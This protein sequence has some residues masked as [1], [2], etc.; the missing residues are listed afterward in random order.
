MAGG[1]DHLPLSSS[2][3]GSWSLT[4]AERFERHQ[5][6]TPGDSGLLGSICCLS[7]PRILT[8]GKAATPGPG[9]DEER[10]SEARSGGV[11]I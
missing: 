9:T 4:Q 3:T 6:G 1:L 8:A 7:P 10:D 5:E 2:G 11:R